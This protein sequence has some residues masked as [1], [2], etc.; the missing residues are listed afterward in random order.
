M[1]EEKPCCQICN[2]YN[3]RDHYC[4]Y[5]GLFQDPDYCCKSQFYGNTSL[6]DCLLHE[7]KNLG[8]ASLNLETMKKKAEAL[9]GAERAAALQEIERYCDEVWYSRFRIVKATEKQMRRAD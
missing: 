3:H 9:E 1:T 7:C 5:F 8:L 2:W 6:E 4:R